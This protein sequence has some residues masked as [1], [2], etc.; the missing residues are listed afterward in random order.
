M[1]PWNAPI[2]PVMIV[3]GIERAQDDD[4]SLPL[5]A[6]VSFFHPGSSRLSAWNLLTS[7]AS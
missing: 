4:S 7:N 1:S 6:Y 3:C 5:H 2:V